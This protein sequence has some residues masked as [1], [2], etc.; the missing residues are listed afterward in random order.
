[1]KIKIFLIVTV[2]LSIVFLTSCVP[3]FHSQ[4]SA[5]NFDHTID[6]E[7]NGN[8]LDTRTKPKG[9]CKKDGCFEVDVNWSATIWFRLKA[10]EKWELTELKICE[11]TTKTGSCQLK[12]WQ[13]KDFVAY[14]KIGGTEIYP[15]EHGVIALDSLS[16]KPVRRFYLYDYN[17]NGSEYHYSI[18]ACPEGSREPGDCVVL[19]PPIVN[20][21]KSNIYI[22]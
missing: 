3:S 17:S 13:T 21:G 19:D 8:V 16:S 22:N 4:L 7:V 20:K 5:R 18:T 1:M 10:N 15:D 12:P 6:L 9:N 11:G 14:A 2:L